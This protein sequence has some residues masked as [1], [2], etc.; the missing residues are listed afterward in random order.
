MLTTILGIGSLIGLAISLLLLAWQT[1]AVAK[2]TAAVARQA[3]IENGIAAAEVHDKVMSGMREVLLQLV[4]HPDLRAYFYD[5]KPCPH[6]GK[7]RHQVL[8]L[9]EA[10]ADTLS[11]GL[12]AHAWTPS[13]PTLHGW[14][15]Y[16]RYML[17]HSPALRLIVQRWPAWW[18]DLSKLS[19]DG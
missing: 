16:C 19:D 6:R 12:K 9:A 1:R 17:A 7:R 18:P 14:P 10:F 13:A 3:E 2:Q 11:S 8:S 5:G 4:A 15:Q